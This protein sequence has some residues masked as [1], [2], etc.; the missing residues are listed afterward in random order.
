MS[1][2]EAHLGSPASVVDDPGEVG[3]FTPYRQLF[4]LE[5]YW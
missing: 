3:Q 5:K 4:E 2:A 1:V